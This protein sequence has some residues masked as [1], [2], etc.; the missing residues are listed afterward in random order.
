MAFEFLEGFHRNVVRRVAVDVGSTHCPVSSDTIVIGGAAL[1]AAVD[2][3][4]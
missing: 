1:E 4:Q 2:K 3:T